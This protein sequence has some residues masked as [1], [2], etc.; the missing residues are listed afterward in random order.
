MLYVLRYTDL[1]PGPEISK[2]SSFQGVTLETKD[3]RFIKRKKPGAQ[4]ANCQSHHRA[5][6]RL[7][8]RE[9]DGTLGMGGSG[10]QTK[11]CRIL[12]GPFGLGLARIIAAH[13]AS[14]RR[15]GRK[16]H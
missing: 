8:R 6:G 4:L 16:R 14:A 7:V 1:M 10:L 15:N 5:R 3:R 13:R 2:I 9:N 11:S 12:G